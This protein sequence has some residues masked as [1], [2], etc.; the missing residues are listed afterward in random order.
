MHDYASIWCT[1]SFIFN[2]CQILETVELILR[3]V[4]TPTH[5]LVI[6]I[7]MYYLGMFLKAFQEGTSCK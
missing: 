6:Q 2:N 5:P 4:I 3:S 1:V 7:T